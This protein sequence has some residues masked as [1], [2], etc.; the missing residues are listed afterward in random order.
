MRQ[1]SWDSLHTSLNSITIVVA[2]GPS[3]AMELH[4]YHVAVEVIPR[5]FKMK[6]MI[7]ALALYIEDNPINEK[8]KRLSHATNKNI[9]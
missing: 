2:V 7:D 5:V 8:V 1:K 3:T 4:K 9:V 6:P